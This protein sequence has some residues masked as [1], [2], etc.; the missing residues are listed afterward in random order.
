MCSLSSTVVFFCVFN[1]DLWQ[2]GKDFGICYGAIQHKTVC[3][4][5][6][7]KH[8]IMKFDSL[9]NRLMSD[10]QNCHAWE[11]VIFGHQIMVNVA[12]YNSAICGDMLHFQLDL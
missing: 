7:K 3:I 6:K 10:F 9:Y 12:K 5:L 4:I 1:N 2:I 8:C 11:L